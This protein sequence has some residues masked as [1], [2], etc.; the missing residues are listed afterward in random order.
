MVRES[1]V[2]FCYENFDRR[3]GTENRD[4][5]L[6]PSFVPMTFVLFKY[7]P[8]MVFFSCRIFFSKNFTQKILRGLVSPVEIKKKKKTSPIFLMLYF[9]LSKIFTHRQDFKEVII[10]CGKFKKIPSPPHYNIYT[11]FFFSLFFF[12]FFFFFFPTQIGNNTKKI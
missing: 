3:R 11:F 7:G 2:F 5:L 4:L 9:F 10:S 8:V 6:T 1:R 12:F